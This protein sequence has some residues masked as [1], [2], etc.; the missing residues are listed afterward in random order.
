MR[1]RAIV[2]LAAL[3]LAAGLY[4]AL[5]NPGTAK[6]G[7][8]PLAPRATHAAEPTPERAA[9]V[10]ATPGAS[11]VARQPLRPEPVPSIKVAE[12]APTTREVQT[13]RPPDEGEPRV[14]GRVTDPY[15][16]PVAGALVSIEKWVESSP[17]TAFMG[18]KDDDDVETDPERLARTDSRGRFA[19]RRHARDG[20]DP[21]LVVRGRGF[22]VLRARHKL[23]G[24]AV[25]SRAEDL[26]LEP[27]LLVSGIVLDPHGQPVEGA[28]VRRSNDT[29]NPLAGIV[30]VFAEQGGVTVTSKKGLRTGPDGTFEFPY[31]APGAY[32]F[33]AEHEDHPLAKLEGSSAPGAGTVNVA[34]RFGPSAAIEGV[35]RGLAPGR[36]GIQ[37]SVLPI[38]DGVSDTA[39]RPLDLAAML[40]ASVTPGART[41]DVDEQGRFVVRGLEP[42]G[43]Y[44]VCALARSGP[45]RGEPCSE[46]VRLTAPAD[47]AALE[48]DAGGTLTFRV[49]DAE[50]GKPVTQLV[51][52]H[53]WQDEAD[54]TG[55]IRAR[56]ARAKSKP[57]DY[58]EGVVRIE[59]L[60]PPRAG[61]LLGLTINSPDHLEIERDD[62]VIDPSGVT[63]LGVL[64]LVRAPRVRVRVLDDESGEGIS[65]ARVRFDEQGTGLS[66]GMS[67]S[68]FSISV[69]VGDDEESGFDLAEPRVVVGRTDR[70]GV[71]ELAV[72]P[73]SVGR[74]RVHGSR[75]A[76]FELEDVV[77]PA[78]GVHEVEVRLVQS[79]EAVVRTVNTA[80]EITA[81]VTVEHQVLGAQEGDD[82]AV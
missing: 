12:R 63:D 75:Y 9:T 25:D 47:D 60:R 64:S 57:S 27:G 43:R 48:F 68:G 18:G 52:R 34:L 66:G 78:S 55:M 69:S 45:G 50:S 11:E 37:V 24:D 42:G 35:V 22:Q 53:E 67:S 10:L 28:Y 21:D 44:E 7:V 30:N 79:G 16:N 59:E 13:I 2:L 5:R 36:E 23:V 32:A 77:I 70:E 76:P 81:G 29:T 26:V 58:P 8:G 14:S 31:E 20:N 33:E 80:G 3:A 65:K 72:F 4:F 74:L 6:G 56:A 17:I 46:P 62:L 19:I 39:P 41:A 71:C 61:V 40:G 15:G 49:V 73:T 51:V 54:F 1:I 82:P 38:A